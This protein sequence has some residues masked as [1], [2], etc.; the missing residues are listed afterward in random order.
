MKIRVLGSAAGGGFPQWNC[1][2]R[3]CAGLRAGSLQAA[4][5]T[6]TQLA[7]SPDGDV[8]FLLGASPDLR[9]QLFSAPELAPPAGQATGT[10]IGGVF[11]PSADVDAVMGLLHL[12]EFQSFF[13]FST[14]AIQ[15]VLRAENRIFDVLHRAQPP[16]HWQNLSPGS[17]LACRFGDDPAAPPSFVCTP[18]AV[19]GDYPDFVSIETRRGLSPQ[20]AVI[21]MRFEQG[22]KSFFFAPGLAS[23]SGEWLKAAAA[24]D[25]AFFDGTFWSDDELIQTGR[26]SKTAR[27]M[28]HL[29]LSGRGGLLTQFP[30]ASACRK[31]LIHINNTNPILD[32]NSDEHRVVRD[33]GFEI[34]WDGMEITL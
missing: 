29:P 16:V 28:G 25:V 27:E 1:G 14:P 32:E 30:A 3:N 9:T 34:A 23:D 2:C 8:W 19:G 24:S 17:R 4:P 15:R 33:A 13:I 20:E 5:R 22:N 31:I 10:P 18:V 11:L 12:R 7:F 26:G 6:Q 21:A